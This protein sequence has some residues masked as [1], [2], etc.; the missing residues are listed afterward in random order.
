LPTVTEAK[1]L[2]L[3]AALVALTIN[4]FAQLPAGM[5]LPM[6]GKVQSLQGNTL[7]VIGADSKVQT[8]TL[9]A[10]ARIQRSERKTI[11]DIRAGEFVGST[12]VLGSDGQR[13]AKEVHIIPASMGDNG[14][15][16][17]AM[18]PNPAQTMTN[19]NIDGVVS[20]AQGETLTISYKGGSQ[21]IIVDP[22]TSVTA[23]VDAG[24]SALTPGTEVNVMT[25]PDAS[26]K[27]IARTVLIGRMLGR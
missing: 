23:M 18:G 9:A 20:G 26:G 5:P 17:F 24:R 27:T 15:G 19:G 11:S 8:V 2:F 22:E 14:G 7:T 25:A 16:H 3:L 6:Q 21:K 12:S 4:A 10:D 1:Q 13:H